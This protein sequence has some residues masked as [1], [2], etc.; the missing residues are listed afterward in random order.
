MC[1][2]PLICWIAVYRKEQG[3]GYGMMTW[4]GRTYHR[5]D[6]HFR[7]VMGGSGRL[8]SLALQQDA[9]FKRT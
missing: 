8:A 5:A 4:S 1:L 2:K 9:I 6:V 3:E 7:A